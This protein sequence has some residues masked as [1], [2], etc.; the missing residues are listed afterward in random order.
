VYKLNALFIALFTTDHYSNEINIGFS[1][2]ASG[3]VL[4]SAKTVHGHNHILIHSGELGDPP[5][6]KVVT[7]ILI[8]LAINCIFAAELS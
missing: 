3:V 7:H 8:N 6:S 2:S 5:C 1:F 4:G